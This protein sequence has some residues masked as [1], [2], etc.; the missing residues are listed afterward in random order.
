MV[1]LPS[2]LLGYFSYSVDDYNCQ[3]DSTNLRSVFMNGSLVY[4]I[5]VNI[6]NGCYFYTLIKMR[7][8]NNSLMETM[9]QIQQI[10]ARRD[11][12]VLFRICVLNGLLYQ[13]FS[14]LQ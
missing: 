4:V 7:Q 11:L 14:Y 13:S 6:I 3:N 1:A 5:R 9:T 8:E 12:V 10:N 2:L